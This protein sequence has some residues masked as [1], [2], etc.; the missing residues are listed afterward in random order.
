MDN[1]PDAAQSAAGRYTELA[2]LRQPFLDRARDCSLVTIP[3]LVPPE[4]HNSHTRLYTPYQ[5]VGARGINNLSSKF[6]LSLFPPDSPF[7]KLV[8]DDF[9]VDKLSGDDA[10]ALRGKVD[11]ALSKY[12]RTVQDYVETHGIRTA[13]F[14][15]FKQL[16]VAGNVMPYVQ[17]DG[18]LRV[19][20]LYEYVVKRDPVGNIT[21]IVTRECVAPSTLKQDVRALIPADD[22]NV[23]DDIDLYTWIKRENDKWAYHQEIGDKII[24]G[25]DGTYPLDKCPYLPLRWARIDGEDYG[26]GYVEEYLGDL[27]SLEGLTAA[28]VDGASA[29]AKILIAVK[30]GS[31]ATPRVVAKARSGDVISAN[32]E[33]IGIVQMEKYADFRTARET[34]GEIQQRL[35]FAFLL[36]TAIQRP[37]ERV[38]AE[39]IRYMAGELEDALG[40]AYSILS[41]EYQL[42]LVNQIIFKLERDNKVPTLPVGFVK[43]AII[44]GIAAL[45]RGHDI[46]KLQT[47]FGVIN[48]I[49]ANPNVVGEINVPELITRV[50]SAAGVPGKG[51][52]K[53]QEQKDSEAQQAQMMQLAAKLGPNAISAM[54]Q[55]GTKAMELNA[56]QPAPDEA[57][58]GGAAA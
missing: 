6:L 32:R 7:F 30:P 2:A 4:G 1:T 13:S 45:G 15:V 52:I 16:L 47:A 29:A 50:L 42:K 21:E 36:N 57:A 11:E 25:T 37:G 38:T 14:E 22:R 23:R 56:N 27:I 39:E 41:Q 55:A 10:E 20:K 35:A 3:A 31:A 12:E 34:A 28:I 26:R 58:P 49:M 43:P 5:S 40:G 51:L 24:T 33:D 8:M 54:G 9:A 18:G 46:N 53:S 17:P 44:T 48:E 19:F